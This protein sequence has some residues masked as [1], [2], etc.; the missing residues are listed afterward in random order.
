MNLKELFAIVLLCC[1]LNSYAAEYRAVLSWPAGSLSD[2]MLRNIAE[3]FN[4]NTG[5]TIVVENLPGAGGIV[6]TNHWKNQNKAEIYVTTTSA[7]VADPIMRPEQL[8]Y[9]DDDFDLVLNIFTGTGVWVTRPDTNIKRPKDLVT[10]MPTLIGG[11]SPYWDLNAHALARYS[12]QPME[13]VNYK[14][15]PEVLQGILGK[16]IDLALVSNGPNVMALVTAGK[17]HIVGSTY[18]NDYTLDGVPLLSVSKYTG[19]PGFSSFVGLAVKPTL[20]P[21]KSAYLK[22]ELWRAVNT[23]EMRALIESS[24][25]IADSTNNQQQIW[26]QIVSLRERVKKAYVKNK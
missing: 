12:N 4:R 16:E 10:R 17:L 3:T 1:S 15:A 22:R 11:Y 6:G 7:L 25:G 19:V 5:D 13:I 21:A 14:G 8:T 20:D 9:T 26:Q 2:T 23:P 24:G 18:H